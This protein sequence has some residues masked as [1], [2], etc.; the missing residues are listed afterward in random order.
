M[1]TGVLSKSLGSVLQSTNGAHAPNIQKSPVF[2][3]FLYNG[4]IERQ[5]EHSRRCLYMIA[6]A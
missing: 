4:G 3:S 1:L 2:Q 6:V 5:Y